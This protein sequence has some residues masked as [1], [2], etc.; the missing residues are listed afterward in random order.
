MNGSDTKNAREARNAV[1]RTILQA[2]WKYRG[3][4][5]AALALLVAAKLLMVLVPVLLKH[6]V[7]TLSAPGLLTLPVFLLLG[8][9]LVRFGGSVFT[10]LRDVVFSQVV[11]RTV[12]D[13]TVSVF[14]RLQR[15]G[16]R[17][18]ARARPAR[19]R[20]TSSAAPP[21]SVSCWEP[22]CSRCCRPWWR[23]CRWC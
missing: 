8:Y 16:S 6:I 3:R 10:E 11:Q 18:M 19:W 23:S 9:A 15:L 2:L 12:A 22:A 20:G 7:D 21:V 4:T 17:F 13:F 14:S 1:T 5:A